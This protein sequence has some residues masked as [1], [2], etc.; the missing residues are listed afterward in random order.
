MNIF[1]L[2]A[3]NR[4][5]LTTHQLKRS[6]SA[7]DS[8]AAYAAAAYTAAH[9][10]AYT[11]AYTADAAYATTAAAAANAYAAAYVAAYVADTYAAGHWLSEYFKVTGESMTEYEA[12]LERDNLF[13]GV[14]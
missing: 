13:R 11:Y 12:E 1:I 14:G 3:M 5:N 9:A 6:F 7:A 8:Y 10:D 2:N 4:E